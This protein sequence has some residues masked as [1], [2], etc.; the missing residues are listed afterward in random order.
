MKVLITGAS[1][2][3][4]YRT[5]L[6]MLSKGYRVI[7]ASF[8]NDIPIEHELLTKVRV[9]LRDFDGLSR[10]FKEHIP[11][12]VVHM[13]AYGD[14]D[15]CEKNPDLAWAIN[16][17]GTINLVKLAEI[18]SDYIL[19]LSTDYVFDG[20]RGGY[21]E[22]E[23]PKPV[24]YYG[25]TKLCGE[26]AVASSNIANS[27]VR[28]SSIYGLGPGRK[29][30][31]KFL[32]E[33]LSAGRKVRA[34]VDQYTTPTQASA[35]ADAVTEILERKLTGV[36]HVVGE[37]MSRYEFAIKIAET[38]GLKKE[39][40]VPTK[41]EE[42]KWYANRPKDSSLDCKLTRTTLKVDFYSTDRV[43]K[44]TLNERSVGGSA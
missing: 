35:L 23:V 32:L 7:G 26:V 5:T 34:L 22:Q 39:L 15:G 25:L 8:S 19:Y 41:M 27:I 6:S 3:P 21:A 9:D 24:N 38:F 17:Q 20:L 40:I 10:I 2:L 16:V 37:K 12:A 11:D 1:S 28:A 13:A 36:F 33:E 42:M 4:G 29:N 30:F 44:M 31:A 14:V 18:F 43:M